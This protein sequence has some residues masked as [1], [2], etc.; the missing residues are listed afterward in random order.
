MMVGGN[1]AR[2]VGVGDHKEWERPYQ[3]GWRRRLPPPY[4]GGA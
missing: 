2:L 3:Y 1:A 4:R